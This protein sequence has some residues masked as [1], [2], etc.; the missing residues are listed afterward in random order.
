[1]RTG[2]H[3][4]RPHPT[5]SRG[6][7]PLLAAT[8]RYGDRVTA[9][10]FVSYGQN[11]EDVVLFRALRHVE[12][13]HYIEIGANDPTVDSVSAPFYHRGWSGITVEPVHAYAERHRAERQRDT[14][15]EAAI[16][17]DPSGSVVLHQIADT[18]LSSLLDGVGLAHREAGWSVTEETVP[19]RRLDDIL[20]QVGWDGVD[21]QFMIVDTE[22]AERTVLDTIDL[23]R[24]RPWVL[25]IEA[26]EPQSTAPSHEAWESLVLD[27]G[28]LFCLFDGLSR[29]YVA[30]ERDE[31]LHQALSYPACVH[32]NYVPRHVVELE[33]AAEQLRQD[34]AVLR[35]EVARVPALL[36][37][38]DRLEDELVQ[39]RGH[40]AQALA[41]A[42]RWRQKAVEAWAN[43]SAATD[44]NMSELLFLREHAHSLFTELGAMRNTVSWRV[45]APLRRVRRLT[46]KQN[47]S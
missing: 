35:E 32:D 18:G 24:W 4:H 30:S 22:G 36:E 7:L 21:I 2:G 1:M 31:Q 17:D 11:A 13:G 8:R 34:T 39:A 42:L 33:S 26:T 10:R 20:D 5:P 43:S 29:F 45:T 37:E 3:R 40:E 9:D 19:A 38:R 28:Y 25:V 41:S 27:A 47:Q 15:I 23:H 6:S 44:A 46:P 12:S 14:L 16:S